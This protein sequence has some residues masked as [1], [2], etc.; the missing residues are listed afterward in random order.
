MKKKTL[1][2]KVFSVFNVAFMLALCVITLFPYLNVLALSLND[3][4]K[5]IPSGLMLIPKVF[6]WKNYAALLSNASIFRAL[7]VSLGRIAVGLPLT[8]IITFWAAYGL[9]RKNLPFR[10]TLVFIFFIPS[11]FSI[12]LIPQYILFDFLHL[13]DNPLVYVLPGSFAFF[14]YI[15]FRAYIRTIPESLEES[16]RLDG[17]SDFKIMYRIYLPLCLPI[18][19]T[20]SLFTIVY[21]WNDWTTTLYFITNSKWNVLAF[22]LERV[23]REQDRL[24]ALIQD[25]IKNGQIPSRSSTTSQELKYTEI[26]ITTAPIIAA[27]PFL[28]KY[29]IKGMLIGGVKE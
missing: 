22:E 7:L 1:P 9:T 13:L 14:N 12:G 3:G 17:A 23:L 19:A 27:Y 2:E 28:Q 25:A 10:K 26:I 11:V 6:T 8:L 5:A 21:H 24:T 15:L 16:A 29:F 20:I 18:I 4:M